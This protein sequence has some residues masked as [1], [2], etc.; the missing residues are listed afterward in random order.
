MF[1]QYGCSRGRSNARQPSDQ[2]LTETAE[3]LLCLLALVVDLLGSPFDLLDRPQFLLHDAASRGDTRDERG[4]RGGV[5]GNGGTAFSHAATVAF[6]RGQRQSVRRTT[7]R[8]MPGVVNQQV[9]PG[10]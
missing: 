5:G 8:K 6:E 1:G 10:R 9:S 3:R 2:G 4:E 7:N